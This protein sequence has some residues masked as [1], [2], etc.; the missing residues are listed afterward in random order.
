M[1]QSAL[2]CQQITELKK[3]QMK[4]SRN[5]WVKISRVKEVVGYESERNT[6][7]WEWSKRI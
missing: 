5:I 3:K 4:N 7:H 1:C 2:K 6:E